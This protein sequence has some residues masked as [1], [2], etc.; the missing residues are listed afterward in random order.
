MFVVPNAKIT[1]ILNYT[2]L[3]RRANKA[4]VLSM[5]CPIEDSDFVAF[6]DSNVALLSAFSTV[7]TFH[8]SVFSKTSLQNMTFTLLHIDLSDGPSGS[9]QHLR[10]PARV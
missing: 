6:L 9:I 3:S 8:L 7:F 5:N 1:K 4:L 10:I 2:E